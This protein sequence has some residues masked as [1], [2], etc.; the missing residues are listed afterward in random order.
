VDNITLEL[1][2]CEPTCVFVGLLIRAWAHIGIVGLPYLSYLKRE[3]VENPFINHHCTLLIVLV[4]L[5]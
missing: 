5:E 1:H 3:K 4:L 2:M